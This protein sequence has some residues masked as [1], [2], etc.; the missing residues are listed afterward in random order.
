MKLPLLIIK[1]G[2]TIEPLLRRRGDFEDWFRQGLG[3]SGARVVD[4]EAGERLPTVS[5][6]GAAVITGSPAMV[7]DRLPWSENTAA[8]LREA[9]AHGVWL[10]GV[11]YGHQL[12]AHALGAPVG[13]NPRGPEVGTSRVEL[14]PEGALDPLVGH[15]RTGFLAQTIHYEAVLSPPVGARLLGTSARDP[16]QAFAL[17]ERVWGLQFHPEFDAEVLSTYVSERREDL[18]ADGLDPEAI[19]DGIRETPEAWDLLARFARIVGIR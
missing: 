15:L 6:V 3:C 12:L 9:M 2:R 10:L 5:E 17:G 8:W 1:T 13:P 11:C 14:T 19:L 4:V 16:C 18:R 7:S